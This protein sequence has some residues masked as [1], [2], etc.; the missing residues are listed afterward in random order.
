M[1]INKIDDLIDKI[2]D[3]FYNKVIV[4]E[5]IVD[6]IVSEA[7]F[8][9]YQK[10]INDIFIK[11]FTNIDE[12]EVSTIVKNQDNVKTIV[13]IFK[14]YLAMYFFLFIGFNYSNKDETYINNIV[15][16]SKNQISYNLKITNFFNSENNATLIK[17]FKFIKNIMTL[18]T[19]EKEKVAVM[20]TRP[21][22]KECVEFLNSLGQ[23]FIMNNFINIKLA[24]KDQAHN[25]I[26][27]VI[28]L[29]LY[30]KI[31]KKEV[32][33]LLEAVETSEGEYIFID[34]LFPTKQIIDYSAVEAVLTKRDLMYG[35][36]F[37]FWNYI[38]ENEE[39]KL[40][41]SDSVDDKILKLI[42][43]KILVPIVDDFLLYHKD[44][45]RYDKLQ[46]VDATQQTRNKKKD[47]TKIRY[48]VNKIE[49]VSDYYSENTQKNTKLIT[50]IKKNF[51]TPLANRKAVL[52]NRHEEVR[53]I[54][55][56][57]NQG[58]KSLENSEY[59][60]DLTVYRNYP[61]INFKDIQKDGFGILLDTTVDLVRQVSFE[62]TGDNRQNSS[63]KL[64]L[65]VGSK[66]QIVNVV[67]FMIPTNVRALEC[68]K[69]KDVNNIRELSDNKN[70]AEL[71]LNF[72]SESNIS[73]IKHNSSLFWFFDSQHDKVELNTYEQTTKLNKYEQI[74]LMVSKLYDN[75]IEEIYTMIE[76]KLDNYD[77]IPVYKSLKFIDNSFK[78]I[79][80]KDHQQLYDDLL[81]KV[82]FKKAKITD[83]SYDINEDIFHGIVGN[84][85]KLPH[86]PEKK[87]NNISTVKIDISAEKTK[88][89][90][91]EVEEVDGVCQHNISWEKIFALR[92]SNPNKY[93]DLLYEFI[94]QYVIENNEQDYVCKS[95]GTLINL[96]KYILEGSYDD[97]TQKYVTFSTPMEVS[98]EDIPEY[99]KFKTSIRAIDKLI[100]KLSIIAN[101][102]YFIGNNS[103]VRTRRKSVTKDVIDLV[104]IN[105]KLLKQYFKER[106]E[107]SN[108]K[109]GVSRDLSNLFVFE[110]D[111]GI[112]IFSSKEK[113]YYK[114]IKLNNIIAYMII[115]IILEV[116][117]SHITFMGGSSDKKGLCNFD[118]FDKYGHVLFDGL[119][120]P[121]NKNGDV[122]SIKNYRVLCYLIYIISCMATKYSV[123]AYEEEQ[124]DQDKTKKTKTKVKK[125]NPTIQKIIIHTVIDILNS[126]IENSSKE[127]SGH[128]YEV[129]TTK[130]FLKLNTTFNSESVLNK[131]RSDKDKYS[132]AIDR[133][134]YVLTKNAPIAL[135]GIYNDPSYIEPYYIKCRHPKY[136]IDFRN[137]QF[138]KYYNINNITNCPTGENH[139]WIPNGKTLKCTIC[140]SILN[141]TSYNDKSEKELIQN[142]IYYRLQ[143]LAQ[144]FCTI[145]GTP[146]NFIYDKDKDKIICVKCRRDENYKYDKKELLELETLINKRRSLSNNN[147]NISNSD[148]NHN[149]SYIDNVIQKITKSYDESKSK[150]NV[151][152]FLDNF[153]S[154]I[155]ET[156]GSDTSLSNDIYL[157]DNV[158][159]ID[160]D[161]LGMKLDKPILITDKDGK[162]SYK[163]NHSFF[164]TDVI[165]Y[166]S[167][168]TGRIETFYDANNYILLGYKEASKDFMLTK[169][170]DKRIK[171]NYSIYNKLKLL[172]YTS[173][174]IDLSKVQTENL[175]DGVP[176]KSIDQEYIYKESLK[177]IM[178][179]RV[180][181]LK[182]F[183]YEF[184]RFLYRIKFNYIKNNPSKDKEE[185]EQKSENNDE[186]KNKDSKDFKEEEKDMFLEIIE[187]HQK[188]LNN[189][190]IYDSTK[191]HKVFKHWKAVQNKINFENNNDIDIRI[192]SKLIDAEDIN[193]IDKFGNTILY[194][195]VS[196]MTKLLDYNQNKFIKVNIINFYIDFINLLFNTFNTENVINNFEVKKFI[197]S[198]QSSIYTQFMEEQNSLI[199]LTSGI[200]EEYDDDETKD[201]QE[202]EKNAEKTTDDVEESQALD[203]DIDAENNDPDVDGD[204]DYEDMNESNM[205]RENYLE[206]LAFEQE[207]EQYY[208]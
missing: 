63:N 124:K 142:F 81:E 132:I 15:E 16:F 183:I 12:K 88:E 96:K 173:K 160:H 85:I 8:V 198:L 166:I 195:I 70:C 103:M 184:Q 83:S 72:L 175:E 121:K 39:G 27:T 139:N 1:Y 171:I 196:E 24:K 33:N 112:F 167:M 203:L 163:K 46:P 30:K 120:I 192:E 87:S 45:E 129:L 94:Q 102:P 34:V 147:K 106:N 82:F 164:K 5:K 128:I 69:V 60:S 77:S 154:K 32:F 7:N 25:I 86:V 2:L 122:D 10:D 84:I 105:N 66:D 29:A 47:D 91:G 138:D 18:L 48:I 188:K 26:K 21:D 14:R 80:L 13:E 162:I 41:K 99:E 38:V 123:W 62:K 9:K 165:S 59:I 101:I 57:V 194:Y 130:F 137:V 90:I 36:A 189:I 44:N 118:V 115:L 191:E 190:N 74:K 54:S 133:K 157:K 22:F 158:Y 172:G 68:L 197:Y 144:K 145:D 75:I 136:N 205:E 146:H 64:Q 117:E 114:K 42:N 51:Y 97:D 119:K 4:K 89:L 179:D 153:I 207:R 134:T 107:L 67:G 156:I 126:I 109:Y 37:E 53:I 206:R 55:K 50:E 149:N 152:K 104:Q 181:N 23:E 150:D 71:T 35:L 56:L 199:N 141:T 3:D 193:I 20:I 93:A 187:K 148:N 204:M 61:Y 19:T 111:N 151:Y 185:S 6:K 186:Q 52:V 200:Y 131:F 11:Y 182:K 159:I 65:R 100:E 73:T 108:K 76:T 116:N 202:K 178:R 92:K 161:H 143:K 125:F 78:N 208:N 135:S 31:E 176:N 79:N 58:R 155:Q 113:D 17:H 49:N 174:Y 140:D 177:S 98:L 201:E 169:N 95:C 168:K 40:I 28:V 43:S 110:L 170:P 127:K 180:H